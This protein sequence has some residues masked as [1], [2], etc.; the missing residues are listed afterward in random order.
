MTES[1]FRQLPQQV[2]DKLAYHAFMWFLTRSEPAATGHTKAIRA[3]CKPIVR[4]RA[5]KAR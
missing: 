2:K 4:A 3:I 1:E 5:E